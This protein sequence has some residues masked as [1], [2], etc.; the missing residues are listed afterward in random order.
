MIYISMFAGY[1][2][3]SLEPSYILQQ[4]HQTFGISRLPKDLQRFRVG[5]CIAARSG[6]GLARSSRLTST[7]E[8]VCRLLSCHT[9]LVA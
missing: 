9:D 6:I 4:F 8:S 5:F 3:V 7:G 2:V 1:K